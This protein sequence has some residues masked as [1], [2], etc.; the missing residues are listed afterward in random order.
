MIRLLSL[1]SAFVLLISCE[2]SNEDQWISLMDDS[3]WKGYLMEEMPTHWVFKDG[4]LICMEVEN[5][6][7][8]DLITKSSYQNF[9]LEL[10]WNIMPEGNSGIFYHIVEDQQYSGP[11]QTAPE[12]QLIDDI[13]FPAELE[14]WQKSGANYAMHTPLKDNLFKGA[15][16]W[17]T[18]KIVYDRGQIGRAHV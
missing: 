7:Q 17:N 3:H 4:E 12:Y 16:Q 10:Q 2:S 9:V 18:T 14:D 15:K 5:K 8:I 1:I 13:N 11:Y 6:P